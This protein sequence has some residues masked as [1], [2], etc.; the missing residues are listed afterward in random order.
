MKS[1]VS[2]TDGGPKVP[3]NILRDS[4]A[5]QLVLLQGVL[6]LSEQT[7]TNPSALLRGF[8][9]RFVLLP[10]H[11]IHLESDLVKGQV[12]VG[13]TSEFSIDGGVSYLR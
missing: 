9:M 11:L 3:I 6:P 10:L 13:V 7:S 12:V 5:S 4:A 1:L 2:L 8:V